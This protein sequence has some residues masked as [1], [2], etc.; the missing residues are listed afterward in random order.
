MEQIASTFNILDERDLIN[1]LSKIVSVNQ[2]RE[3]LDANTC[4]IT[5]EIFRKIDNVHDPDLIRILNQACLDYIL[6]NIFPSFN[7]FIPICNKEEDITTNYKT[8]DKKDIFPPWVTSSIS[9]NLTL[10][11]NQK[12]SFILAQ[13]EVFFF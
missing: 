9:S 7:K 10:Q 12:V 11:E 2:D 5:F 3:F 1:L 6:K 4:D 8:K 13:T